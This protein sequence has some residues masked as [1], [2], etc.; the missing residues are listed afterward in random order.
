MKKYVHKHIMTIL[1]SNVFHLQV[2]ELTISYSTVNVFWRTLV[3][4]KPEIVLIILGLVFAVISGLIYPSF[5]V[6]LG[7]LLEV[8]LC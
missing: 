4:N 3:L 7:E 6:F 5:A 2:K 1:I 8:G